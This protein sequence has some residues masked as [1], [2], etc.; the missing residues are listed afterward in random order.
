MRRKHEKILVC[1]SLNVCCRLCGTLLPRTGLRPSKREA[2]CRGV[3]D[4]T[5]GFGFIDEKTREIVGYDVDFVRAIAKKM[6]VKLELKSVTSATRMPQLTAG[7]IDMIAA[8]MTKTAERAKQIDFSYTYFLTGQKF[9]VKKGPVKN[10]ADLDGKG[11]GR[12]RVPPRSRTQRRPSPRRRSFPS[13]TIPQAFLALQQGKVVAVTTDESIL[14]SILGKAPDK[15]KYEIPD[16]RISD[17]PYG[18]GIRK[19]KRPWSTSSTRPFWKWRKAAKPRRFLTNGLV[20]ILQHIAKSR[21]QDYGRKISSASVACLG[22]PLLT[23]SA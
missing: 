18:L 7:N 8:T 6:G 17:E 15:D 4:S 14:A 3:K 9:I 11:S 19:A 21:F 12:P 5:P 10:L 22:L 20:P 16:I 13:T 1:S 2:F 23:R